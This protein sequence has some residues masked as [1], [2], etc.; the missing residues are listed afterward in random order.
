MTVTLQMTLP[1]DRFLAYTLIFNCNTA[2][3]NSD[4]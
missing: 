3:R 4:A 2:T 1:R